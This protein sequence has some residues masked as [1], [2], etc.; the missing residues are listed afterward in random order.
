MFRPRRSGASLFWLGFLT[1]ATFLALNRMAT[2]QKRTWPNAGEDPSVTPVSGPSW[3]NHI[4]VTLRATWIGQGSQRYGPA[5]GKPGA[6]RNESLGVRRVRALT[7]ADLYR[8]NCQ[9]CHREAGTGAPPEIHS[10]LGPVQ[11]SSIAFVREQLRARHDTAVTKDSRA[12]ANQARA[13]IL[14]RLHKGGTR[15][16]PRDY[17]QDEDIQVLFTYLTELAGVPDA[18]RQATRTVSWARLGEL[19][20]KGTCHICHDAVG[21]RPSPGAM[22]RGA[23]PSLQSL[24]GTRSVAEF[25]HK[26]RNGEVVRMG[27]AGEMHRGRMPVFY[28]LDDE[29]I[30][31]AYM[32]LA[33]YQPR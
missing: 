12:E 20:V 2:A 5:P 4:G 18:G 6:P 14:A 30:A 28:Y 1:L 17:L 27:E 25:V 33:T 15:M 31:A 26:A 21:P 11:G 8:L 22:L 24:L 7:G 29:E 9:A 13:K 3:L 23:I 19:T 10:L 16:P 32:Y